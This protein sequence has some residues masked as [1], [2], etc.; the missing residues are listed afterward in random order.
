[1]RKSEYEQIHKEVADF[2]KSLDETDKKFI[3]VDYDVEETEPNFMWEHAFESI[4]EIDSVFMTVYS[5][6]DY[7]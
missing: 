5:D 4:T 3:L 2:L 6:S 1:M 7:S